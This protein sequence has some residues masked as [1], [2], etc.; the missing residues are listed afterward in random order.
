MKV[1]YVQHAGAL[2]G[3]VVSL[4]F[5]IEGM[6]RNGHGVTVA[7]VEPDRRVRAKYESCGATVYDA[8]DVPLFRHTTAGWAHAGAPRACAYQLRALAKCRKGRAAVARLLEACQPD[9]VHLNSVTLALAAHGLRH[10]SVP[11]VWHVREAPVRGYL[12]MRYRLLRHA[13][14]HYADEVIFLSPSDKSA[15][16]DN[17][18]G[19]VIP[20]VLPTDEPPTLAAIQAVR[21]DFGLR[22]DDRGIAYLG[23]YSEIKGIF[24][25]ISAMRTIAREFPHARVL[26]PGLSIAPAHNMR[27]KIGR[28]LFPLLGLARDFERAVR[29]IDKANLPHVFRG[30]PFCHDVRPVLAA[31][32]FVVFPSTRPHFARPVVEAAAMGRAAIGS[33]LAGVRDLIE[34]EVTGL[35]VPPSAPDALAAAMRRLLT[36]VRLCSEMGER[37]RLQSVSRFNATDQLSSI[38]GIYDKVLQSRG[39]ITCQ[40]TPSC[41]T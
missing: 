29:L 8:P 14:M 40:R 25:L 21:R 39:R 36:D 22:P 35:H 12:G 20:N 32:E 41:V 28:V 18:R 11:V 33:D 3:S 38:L 5:L 31:C 10:A 30:T 27:S 24:T 19:V 1:L 15:W 16:V 2:G 7:L 23:G 13:L 17:R 26:A 37:A 6:I 9:V 4:G 34:H